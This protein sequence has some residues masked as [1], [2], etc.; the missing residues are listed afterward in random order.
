MV[1]YHEVSEMPSNTSPI[2]SGS[3]KRTALLVLLS[4][5]L[6]GIAFLIGDS[7]AGVLVDQQTG[8][9]TLAVIALGRDLGSLVV[10]GLALPGF[11]LTAAS[12]I[13]MTLLRYGRRPPVWVWAKIGLT[14]GALAISATFVAPALVA[15]RQW[16]QWSVD[17][18]ALA[19]ELDQSASQAAV[20]SAVIV[21]IFL[22]NIPVAVWKPLAA[23]RW[24]KVQE[25]RVAR[26]SQS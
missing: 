8:H 3:S 2:R 17:H 19:P 9:G 1:S 25:Q 18:G 22:L 26:G 6:V 24:P 11:L 5:H 13:A 4:L 12:G 16:A 21:V 10:R 7:V 20:F 23:V 14:L 15:A